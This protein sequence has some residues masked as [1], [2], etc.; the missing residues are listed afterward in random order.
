MTLISSN[1]KVTEFDPIE[2]NIWLVWDAIDIMIMGIE[3]MERLASLLIVLWPFEDLDYFFNHIFLFQWIDYIL[4]II[5][6]FN[7]FIELNDIGVV[8]NIVS[9]L[10]SLR[11]IV[12]DKENGV[13]LLFNEKYLGIL[14]LYSLKIPKEFDFPSK[15]KH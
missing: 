7:F 12:H 13:F 4:I 15:G 2:K 11:G 8:V 6:S 1:I 14:K 9:V 10:V 3:E 5:F